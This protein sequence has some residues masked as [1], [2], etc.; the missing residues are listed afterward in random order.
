MRWVCLFVVGC[1][2]DEGGACPAGELSES[3][4]CGDDGGC[5]TLDSLSEGCIGSHTEQP[6]EQGD[7]S[8]T[9]VGGDD[10]A[11]LFFDGNTMAAVR[12][13]GEGSSET[14][15]DAWFG[16]DLSDCT[17]VGEPVSV[18]CESQGE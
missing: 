9:K 6:C 17:P 16:L 4:Y 13:I 8:F 2:G 15:P 1:T 18:P 11:D 14:C 10:A 12:Q 5:I 7:E 3:A